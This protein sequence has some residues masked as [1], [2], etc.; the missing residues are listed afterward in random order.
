MKKKNFI[1]IMNNL[2]FVPKSETQKVFDEKE[3]QKLVQ[4]LK[5]DGTL[6]FNEFCSFEDFFEK[7]SFILGEFLIRTDNKLYYKKGLLN[8]K[9]KENIYD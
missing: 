7:K 1:K 8:V 9:C 4:T 3:F 6:S 5:I 2:V